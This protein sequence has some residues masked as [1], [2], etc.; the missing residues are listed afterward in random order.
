VLRTLKRFVAQTV[1]PKGPSERMADALRELSAVRD[2]DDTQEG[3]RAFRE[4][5][6]ASYSGR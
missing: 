3:M 2:S 1:M 4:K 5:R 6:A